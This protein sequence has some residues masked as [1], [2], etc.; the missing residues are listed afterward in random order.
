[1]YQPAKDVV[2]AAKRVLFLRT[3]TQIDELMKVSCSAVQQRWDFLGPTMAKAADRSFF[4]QIDQ[5]L[6]WSD[7]RATDIGDYIRGSHFALEL[8]E[9]QAEVLSSENVRFALVDHETMHAYV[10]FA[11]L[12]DGASTFVVDLLQE[13]DKW[14]YFGTIA[15]DERFP[16]ASEEMRSDAAIRNT[17]TTID[18]AKATFASKL[19][20][21]DNGDSDSDG[22]DYWDQFLDLDAPEPSPKP[23][24]SAQQPPES[25]SFSKEAKMSALPYLLASSAQCAKDAGISEAEF[26]NL[27]QAIFKQ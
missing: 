27:A 13:S 26:L 15:V 25:P 22:N 12:Q 10:P 23:A 21:S 24:A 1:M 18:D 8:T 6:Q 4:A 14:L 20:E 5:T 17:A 11:Y 19:N 7:D 16:P 2:E 3:T 9:D